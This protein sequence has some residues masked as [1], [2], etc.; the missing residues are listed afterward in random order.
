[1]REVRARIEQLRRLRRGLLDA[2]DEER[3]ALEDEL[4]LG[5]LREADALAAL[6]PDGEL[7][8]EVA[9]IRAELSE[10]ARGL[11][12]A[13]L[14]EDGLVSALADA[15]RRAPVPVD[16]RSRL[17]GTVLPRP[18]ALAAYYVAAEALANLAEHAHAASARLELW[19]DS[20]ELRLR[21]TDDGAGGADPAGGGL[22]GLRDRLAAVDG[23]LRIH[24]PPAGGTVVEARLP[25]W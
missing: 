15:A 20:G 9:R 2:A 14:A 12:P 4:R 8:T 16:V 7:A 23:E 21:V 25:L 11:Y 10:I 5:P 22:S 13:T 24:S 18:V 17:D 6:L 19:T 3:R 1:V